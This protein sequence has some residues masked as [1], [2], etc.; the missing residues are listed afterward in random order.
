M[1]VSELAKIVDDIAPYR[2]AENWDNVGLQIGNPD[3]E[4]TRILVALEV[5]PAVIDEAISADVQAIITHH[6]L[7]FVPLRTVIESSPVARMSAELIRAEIALIVSHTNL[8]SV[9]HGTNGEIADRLG[10]VDR[11]FLIPSDVDPG[12]G[13]GIIGE[14]RESVSLNRFCDIVKTAFAVSNIG[15]VGDDSRLIRRVAICSGSGGEVLRSPKIALADVLVTGEMNHHQCAEARDLG[16]AVVLVGHHAS[17]VIVCPRMARLIE[18][19]AAREG[20]KIQ[21]KVSTADQ[22]PLRRA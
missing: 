18:E 2:L 6:P 21:A 1:K 9:E 8:D 19:R 17:E 14:M 16:I 11:E 12:A 20:M 13:L 7:I 3:R 5:T 4:V 15:V 22:A 10:I